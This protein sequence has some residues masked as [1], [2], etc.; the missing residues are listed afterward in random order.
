MFA[1]AILIG[2]QI[3]LSILVKIVVILISVMIMWIYA[4]VDHPNKPIISIKRRQGF[5][6]L[7][8]IAV[9][10]LGGVSFLLPTQLG[11]TA[12]MALLIEAITLPVGKYTN[13]GGRS[14]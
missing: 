3:P 2:K 11:T 6:I 8:I 9:I 14:L 10:V 12:V 13:R 1:G 4:P 7:S 5:K